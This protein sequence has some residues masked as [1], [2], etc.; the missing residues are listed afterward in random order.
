[1]TAGRRGVA[2][3]PM[4]TRRDVMVRAARLA[5][6][7]G[8]EVFALPEGWGLDSTTV[9]A[10][11]ASATDRIRLA[12]GVLSI[13]GRT[14]ATLAMTAATLDQISGGRY[15]LGLGASTAALAEGFHDVPFVHPADRLAYTVSTVRALLAGEPAPLHHTPDARPLRLGLPPA[16]AV[17]I[18][19]AALGPRTVQ[20]AAD[21]ADGWFPALVALDRL[22]ALVADLERRPAQQ[23]RRSQP[24]T[25]AA[26]PLVVADENAGAARDIAAS[27]LAWYM[28]AMGDVYAQSLSRQG[29]DTE[30][31]AVRAANPHPSPRTGRIPAAA[32]ALVDQLAAS[33]SPEYVRTQL[34]R[35]DAVAD[36]VMIGLPPGLP[37]AALE[38]TLRVAAPR[39]SNTPHRHAG[40]GGTRPNGRAL[41]T[42]SSSSG[43][44]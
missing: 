36:I 4:E 34:E 16:P 23:A 21:L 2:L 10:E 41:T 8:Y 26:G 17:Q 7:L 37:W 30:V 5:D 19:V 22:T 13:W 24:L 6:E 42:T 3:T 35:W 11:I 31:R 1:M 33:G 14:P 44:E 12:S 40:G 9:L 39:A 29:Y 18:W 38:R 32:E 27:C 28:T 15:L 25:V 43:Q 20:V